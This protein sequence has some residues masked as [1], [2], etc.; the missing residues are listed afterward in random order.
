MAYSLP[1]NTLDFASLKGKLIMKRL[2]SFLLGA[3][4]LLGAAT[5]GLQAGVAKA[6]QRDDN[7]RQ[8]R[9]KDHWNN[10][11]M[12]HHRHRHHRRYRRLSKLSY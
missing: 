3:V 8:R 6:S 4:L 1:N 10:K 2:I 7:A 11:K 12:R 5:F 9:D